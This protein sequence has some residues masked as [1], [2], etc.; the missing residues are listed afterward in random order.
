MT[1]M[2]LAD[3]LTALALGATPSHDHLQVEEAELRVPLLV[4][5]ERGADGPVFLAQ[6]PWS[7]WRSGVEP[8][9]HMAR[10]TIIALAPQEAGPAT[11]AKPDPAG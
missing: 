10:L 6:P 1:R 11:P 7:A 3:T 5:L 9:A 8:V 4:S 2:P